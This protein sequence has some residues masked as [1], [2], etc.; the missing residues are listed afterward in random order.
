MAVPTFVWLGITYKWAERGL[1]G[2]AFL[3]T[4]FLIDI[5]FHSMEIY[6]GDSRG[7]EIGLTDWIMLSLLIVMLT[8][9]RWKN[10]KITLLPPNSGLLAVYLSIAII[11][12]YVAYVQIYAG[13]GLLKILRGLMVFV[14]AY[15]YLQDEEDLRFI[16]GVLALIVIIEFVMV[17]DQRLSGMYRAKGSTPHSNTLAGYINMINMLF[18][19]LLL[20]D[21]SR[22]TLYWI[23]LGL[24]SL[25]VL[26]SFSRGAMMAMIVGY[27]I[28]IVL[29]YKNKFDMRKNGILALMLLLAMPIAIDVGPRVID[30]FLNASEASGAS[31]KLANV[32]AAA[33]A[34]DHFFGVGL[35]NYS[36]AINET[37]YIEHID[38]IVDRGIV[39][40]IYLLHASE[41][42]WIGMIAFCLV[43]GNFLRLGYRSISASSSELASNVAI[44]LTTAIVVL[45]MQGSLE[46][47]FRQTYI[48]IE[49]FMFAGFLVAI[50][51]VSVATN[52]QRK[53]NQYMKKIA[54]SR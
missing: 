29:S 43:I 51:K 10:K 41:M 54:L 4:A 46:W 25:I 52:R 8:S 16:I 7:Y 18:F 32:A 6:R 1:V 21:K 48:T 42:G 33:M 22:P 12:V 28:V 14:V 5:N 17:I 38:S 53:I 49:F 37:H 11:S 50:P 23:V 35:N 31:R 34:D 26:A 27:L 2:I 40:N 45:S 47:F 30:R 39:H 44:G 19:A 24:G 15:N 3:S 20:G 13:F 9:K 36:H